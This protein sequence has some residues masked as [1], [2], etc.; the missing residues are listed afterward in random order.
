MSYTP[1][2]W[3]A[4]QM[5]R[6]WVIRTVYH[7]Q[8]RA[9]RCT[10]FPATCRAGGQDNEANAKLIAA[11]PDLL[12]ALKRILDIYDRPAVGDIAR[13]AIAEVDDA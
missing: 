4:V 5:D 13:A 6:E 1:G 2:V 9:M 3:H 8:R 11:A 7:D 12:H 10:V